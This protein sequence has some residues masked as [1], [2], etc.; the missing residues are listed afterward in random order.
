MVCLQFSV[1][2]RSKMSPPLPQSFTGNAFVLASISS[3]SSLLQQQTLKSIIESIKQAKNSITNE[4]VEIYIKALEGP[5]DPQQQTRPPEYSLPPLKELTMV[6]DWTR[7]PF[8]TVGFMGED[9]AYVCPLVPPL[10]EVALFMQSPKE[11]MD[12]DV[13]IG[14]LPQFFDAFSHYFLGE[15]E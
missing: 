9:A 4:Y 10:P 8:Q 1:D 7:V 11:R 12:V 2:I 15:F 6:S 14:L 5:P 3:T 13:R